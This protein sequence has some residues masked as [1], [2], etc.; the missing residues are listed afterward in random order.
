[1]KAWHRVRLRVLLGILV[2]YLL[3]LGWGYLRLPWAA[4]RSLADHKSVTTAPAVS[5]SATGVDVSRSQQWY[6]DR[7]LPLSP[8]PVVPRVSVV[9]RWNALICARVSSG[10]YVGPTGAEWRDSLY[11]CLF[12][13]WVP[14]YTFS[15]VMA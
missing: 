2:L 9:V 14:V 4:I 1:M 8:T 10:H 11:I 15:H 12:G 13:A 3:G 5:L 7:V 6:L